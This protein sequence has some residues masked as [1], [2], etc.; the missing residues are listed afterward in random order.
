MAETNAVS[1]PANNAVAKTEVQVVLEGGELALFD[2]AIF[3]N[4]PTISK[5]FGVPEPIYDKNDKV[6]GGTMKIAKRKLIAEANGL[7]MGKADRDKLDSK[8]Q[9]EQS[10]AFVAVRACLMTM[11]E[12]STGLYRMSQRLIGA[13]RVKQT[14]LVIR[15]MPKRM[16]DIEKYAASYGL[17]VEELT[18]KLQA[19]KAAREARTVNVSSTVT[20]TPPAKK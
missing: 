16:S 9:E 8:I 17:T 20:S 18:A 12:S 10:K 7:T 3:S 13:D 6:I 19:D 11:S 5:V 4:T 14:T 1:V 2:T 15:D